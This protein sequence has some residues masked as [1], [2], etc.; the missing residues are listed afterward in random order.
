MSIEKHWEDIPPVA[1][2][3]NGTEYGE[4]QVADTSCFKVGMVVELVST[5][6][7]TPIKLKIKRIIGSSIWVGDTGLNIKHR[8][9]ISA[10]LV[11]DTATIH[12]PEQPKPNV[13]FDDRDL[14]TFEHEPV[15]AR[16]VI[17]VDKSGN[18]YTEDNPLPGT[19]GGGTVTE[20]D[21]IVITDSTSTP[22]VIYVGCAVPGTAESA[23]LW[24]IERLTITGNDVKSAYA[25]L[26]SATNVWDDRTSLVY[27]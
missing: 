7:T 25:D 23:A 18:A 10:Y 24:K 5:V 22:G 4:L 1:F 2:T 6:E 15:N 3:A 19:G 13:P 8:T 27:S 16:R 11:A 17:L 9:D 12:A 20:A 26:A 14:A 21:E